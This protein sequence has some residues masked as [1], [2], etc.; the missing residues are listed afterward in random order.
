[1]IYY[2]LNRVNLMIHENIILSTSNERKILEFSRFGLTFDVIKGSDLK[3]VKSTI[4]AVI[5]YKAIA[6][7]DNVLVEDTVL[8]IN[9]EE[10]VD[11]RWKIEELSLLKNPKIQWICSLGIID[12]GTFYKYQGLVDCELVDN[13]NCI[14]IP[15]DAFGFDP[16]LMPC[17]SGLLKSCSFYELEKLGIKDDFS[18]RKHAV[19]NLMNGFFVEEK[20]VSD[21]SSWNGDYQ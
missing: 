12:N 19:D 11:I 20:Q 10:I 18:P 15:N 2:N 21:V 6:A 9:G 5:L 8:V 1:M 4:D 3:E 17:T 14:N 13:I 16:Y 7:G